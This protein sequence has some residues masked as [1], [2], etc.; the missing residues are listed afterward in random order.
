MG[1]FSG[2]ITVLFIDDESGAAF[3]TSEVPS[4]ELPDSFE[5]ATTL[6]MG[7]D[8]WTIVQAEP[9]TRAEYTKSGSLTLRLRRVERIDPRDLLFSLPSI[10]DRLAPVGT[11]PLVG[12]ECLVGEDDWRQ[13]ELVSRQ[14]SDESDAE[15][16]AIRH[17][18][19]QERAGVGWRKIHVRGRPDPPIVAAL[20]RQDI[21][22]S[23]GG[24]II[25][26]GVSYLGAGS[27][28]ESGYSFTAPDG[29]QCYGI[30]Q[31][32]RVTVLGIVRATPT[33]PPIRS[34]DALAEIARQFD[35]D[36]VDWCRCGR[37]SWDTP[38][39]RQRLLGQDSNGIPQS[40]S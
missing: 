24:G 8:D 31:A 12:D 11:D 34:A 19:E 7:D 14:F 10:C 40:R 16:R 5:I 23:F 17:I 29:L 28:I 20:T 18:H 25:F 33:P 15:I 27:P 38:L 2:N 39:F 13:F 4:A 37:T 22:R 36:L 26:R 3:A 6:H 32:G 35:L 9:R 1:L 30:E 21:D